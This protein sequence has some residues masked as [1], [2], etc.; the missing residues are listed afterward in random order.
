ME[1]VPISSDD[2]NSGNEDIEAGVTGAPSMISPSEGL[3]RG[4][5]K[6]GIN[7]CVDK[8]VGNLFFKNISN[9]D[10]GTRQIYEFIHKMRQ[11]FGRDAD[12]M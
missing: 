10:T 9:D 11:E 2:A 3:A 4:A 5:G 7:Q 6:N 8:F 12:R 1:S